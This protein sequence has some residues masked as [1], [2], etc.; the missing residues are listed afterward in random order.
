MKK[1]AILIHWNSDVITFEYNSIEDAWYWIRRR[2]EKWSWYG[3]DIR[4]YII[5]SE[6][7]VKWYLKKWNKEQEKLREQRQER[8]EKLEYTR[9]KKKY[10][11]PPSSTT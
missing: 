2:I 8:E 6:I 11:N 10:D 1:L 3:E 4:W 9:L 7:D 5:E